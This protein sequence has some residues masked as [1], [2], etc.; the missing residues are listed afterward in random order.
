[1]FEAYRHDIAF[2]VIDDVKGSSPTAGKAMT[3]PC[4]QGPLAAAASEFHILLSS[5]IISVGC[6]HCSLP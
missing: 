4:A 3:E 1:M 5:V 2:A 6:P